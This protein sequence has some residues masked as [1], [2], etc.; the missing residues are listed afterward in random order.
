MKDWNDDQLSMRK[1]DEVNEQPA[2]SFRLVKLGGLLK[3]YDFSPEFIAEVRR[4]IWRGFEI[5][6]A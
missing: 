6:D 1:V 5:D 2:Q 4:E 3:G